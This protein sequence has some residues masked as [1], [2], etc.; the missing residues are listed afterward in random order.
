MY[1]GWVVLGAASVLIFATGP[2]H[3]FGV[4]V[5]VDHFIADLHISRSILSLV[6]ASALALSSVLLPIVGILLDTIGVR[7]VVLFAT[8][9]FCFA[10]ILMSRATGIVSLSFAVCLLRFFGPE[11]LVL[12]ANTTINR[13]FVRKRGVAMAL[14]NVVGNIMLAYPAFCTALILRANSWRTAYVQLS[15]MVSADLLF[16]RIPISRTQ[17]NKTHLSYSARLVH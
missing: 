8:L 4:N 9:G 3:S 13:W 12:S 7:P 5:F 16:I 11:C 6:W 17:K 14:S 15:V 1:Y 2:G 10:L